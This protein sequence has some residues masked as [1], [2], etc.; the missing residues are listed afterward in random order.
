MRKRKLKLFVWTNFNPDY[1]GGLAFAVAK[2]E[3]QARKLVIK[4][5]TGME[6]YHWGDLNIY[7]LSKPIAGAVN[8]GT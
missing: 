1:R 8:G 5:N 2:D 6:P 3:T 7:P 4:A